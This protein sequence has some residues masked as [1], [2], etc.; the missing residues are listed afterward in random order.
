MRTIALSVAAFSLVFAFGCSSADPSVPTIGPHGSGSGGT[1]GGSGSGGGNN[2][3]TPGGSG[4]GGGSSSGGSSSGGSSSGGSSSGGNTGGNTI[5]A[6]TTWTGN[7]TLPSATTI[8]AGVT[9]T[10]APGAVVTAPAGATITVAGTLKSSASAQH[11][12]ITGT[13]WGGL[14]IANGGTLALDGTDLENAMVA[15]LVHG[16]NAAAEYDNGVIT[17]ASTPFSVD[18]GGKLTT[19]H[20]SVTGT[21]GQS[22]IKGSFTAS[23][24]SYNSNGNEGIVASDAGAVVTIDDSKLFAGTNSVDM[25]VAANAA[26]VHVGHSEIT[27]THCAFHFDMATQFDI[28]YTSIHGNA[29]GFML[30]GSGS[31]GTRSITYSNIFGNSSYGA[32]ESGTNGLI[33]ISNGYWAQNG[34]NIL[35]S[36]NAITVTNMSTTTPVAGV[37]PRGTL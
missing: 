28:T 27:S 12:K 9:V 1:T 14:V 23:F 4:S 32:A 2:G 15:L 5:S 25:I 34:S 31:T 17:A 19:K 16:G 20:A 33:T 24:M 36:D 29:Y 30:Y 6:D 18:A 26:M 37:G 22:T 3:G 13:G 21:K 35:K 8:A 10:V 7:V 11:A